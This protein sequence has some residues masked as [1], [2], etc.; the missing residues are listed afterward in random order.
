MAFLL[1]VSAHW[2][3]V[4]FLIG[5]TR[6]YNAFGRAKAKQEQRLIAMTSF[7]S[8]T[9]VQEEARRAS[10]EWWSTSDSIV[11]EPVFTSKEQYQNDQ[12]L[13]RAITIYRRTLSSPWGRDYHRML[14]KNSSTG[15][16][17]KFAR[18][19]GQG[20]TWLA[21]R[22]Y[23]NIFLRKTQQRLG[24]ANKWFA[25]MVRVEA[26]VRR[27]DQWLVR[28]YPTASGGDRA[29]ALRLLLIAI[30]L[31]AAQGQQ[32]AANSE[33]VFSLAL[34]YPLVDDYLDG[35]AAIEEERKAFSLALREYI[36]Q[37]PSE[38][39]NLAFSSPH[40]Q[41]VVMGDLLRRVLQSL[42]ESSW[43]LSM[44]SHLVDLEYERNPG[45]VLLATACKGGY[46]LCLLQLLM[47]RSLGKGD[48][49]ILVRLGFVLQLVDD[50]QDMEED[51]AHHS[52]S[53]VTPSIASSHDL[54]RQ[55]ARCINYIRHNL[56]SSY[57][58]WS[59]KFSFEEGLERMM[60]E[61]LVLLC[62]ESAASSHSLTEEDRLVLLQHSPLT[63]SFFL[64]HPLEPSLQ[65]LLTNLSK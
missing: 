36:R 61:S 54:R 63:A 30:Y 32:E 60:R 28:T 4:A 1:V 57:H 49:A 13:L 27:F 11:K 25:A 35:S 33:Q 19:L 21:L 5:A 43:A 12:Q 56:P 15:L 10:T 2:S 52:T 44:F 26:T 45:D 29:K 65:R 42:G 40:P 47:G 62:M 39:T 16:G 6:K 51:V 18:V 24:S 23:S 53:F 14:L 9:D 31:A 46:I 38:K 58:P 48:L 8:L 37:Y 3:D 7:I 20:V 41:S 64:A 50:L 55:Y 17:N 59:K 22:T 34:L